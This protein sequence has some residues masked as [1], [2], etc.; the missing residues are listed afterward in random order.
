[1][2]VPKWVSSRTTLW[3]DYGSD[4]RNYGSDQVVIN[5]PEYAQYKLKKIFEDNWT[6]KRFEIAKLK[7]CR[8]VGVRHRKSERRSG[9][10]DQQCRR[11]LATGIAAEDQS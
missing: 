11:S 8:H 3:E 6:P 7:S 4:R 10:G 5:D 9:P 2:E 1:M